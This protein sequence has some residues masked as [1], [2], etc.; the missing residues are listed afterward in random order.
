[1]LISL[2]NLEFF[3]YHGLYEEE[4]KVGNTFL[5]DVHIQFNTNETIIDRLDQTVD[6]VEIYNLVKAIMLVPTPLLETLVGK[7]AE[8]I[9]NKYLLVEKV[10]VA[11]TKQKLAIAHFEGITTVSIE[12]NRYN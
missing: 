6:Y 4:K 11:I 12:K 2:T 7:M 8:E 10:Q 1:M 9:L 5:V 3:G